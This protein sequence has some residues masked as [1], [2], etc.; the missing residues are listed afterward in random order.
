M[1]NGL[2]RKILEE[3]KAAGT[4]RIFVPMLQNEPLVDRAIDSRVREAY[5]ML[6]EKSIIEIVT[7]GSLLSIRQSEKLVDAGLGRLSVS[8]DAFRKK[9][10]RSIHK[11][12]NFNKVIG[13]LQCFVREYP[14]IEVSARFLKQRLNR[15]EERMFRHFWESR[16]A[17]ILFKSPVNRAG[18]LRSFNYIKRREAGFSRRSIELVLGRVF[19][20][21]PYPFFS[22]NILWNGR[23]I[24]CCNDWEHALPVGNLAS[25]SLVEVWNGEMM[26]H[27]RYLI[28]SGRSREIR[29]CAKCT[30]RHGFWGKT[31][32]AVD[33]GASCASSPHY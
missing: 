30:F 9:T 22:L 12:L 14:Q 1:E 28:Y 32:D 11:G 4:V 19:P 31:R 7:N 17:N 10:Y 6:G 20:F 33:A 3:L 16:G 26:N 25:Q 18:T 21:C 24:L 29:L 27:Y 13:N 23:V 8:V 5:E 15:G 2:Y